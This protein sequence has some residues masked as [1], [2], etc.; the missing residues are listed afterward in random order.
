MTFHHSVVSLRTE[1]HFNHFAENSAFGIVPQSKVIT[2]NK[3]TRLI[4]D[5]KQDFHGVYTKFAIVCILHVNLQNSVFVVVIYSR[6]C[7]CVCA[8]TRTCVLCC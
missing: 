1:L 7:V 6:V 3:V 8:R 5:L 2:S 4:W